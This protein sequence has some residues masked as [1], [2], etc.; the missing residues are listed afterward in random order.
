ML[1]MTAILVSLVIL[2]AYYFGKYMGRKEET[3]LQPTPVGTRFVTKG[4]AE[5]N[6]IIYDKPVFDTIK[7]CQ[8]K[9]TFEV[10][11]KEDYC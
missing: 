11:D 2:F 9:A 6:L 1:S 8:F 5:R 7:N 4:V 3:D 10:I